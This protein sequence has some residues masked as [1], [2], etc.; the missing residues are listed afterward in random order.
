MSSIEQR[1]ACWVDLQQVTFLVDA[2]AEALIGRFD[3]VRRRGESRKLDQADQVGIA[4]CINR[5]S[6]SMTRYEDRA[7]DECRPVRRQL[8]YECLAI[9]LVGECARR[10]RIFAARERVPG[11]HDAATRIDRDSQDLGA[12]DEC[13]INHI[14]I[15]VELEHESALVYAI[16]ARWV[17]ARSRWLETPRSSREARLDRNPQVELSQSASVEIALRVGRQRTDVVVQ[18]IG[19]RAHKGR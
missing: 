7:V 9:Q 19:D 16:V 8:E 6:A 11:C 18:G 13:A 1:R 15:P 14:E 4:L 17:R 2:V 12:I 3:R 10:G 5:D